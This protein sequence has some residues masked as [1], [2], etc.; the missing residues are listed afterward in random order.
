LL[1]GGG[2]GAGFAVLGIPFAFL[3]TPLCHVLNSECKS[4]VKEIKKIGLSFVGL[5]IGISS[6]WNMD[7]FLEEIPSL[8]LTGVDPY[9]PY[10]DTHRFIG[11]EIMNSQYIAT[12]SNMKKE[13][14]SD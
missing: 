9:E 11:E 14:Y 5:E 4:E 1:G 3:H 2:G 6:G 8:T 7:Y 13:I 10:Q 12:L